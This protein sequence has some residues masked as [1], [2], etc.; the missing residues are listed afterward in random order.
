MLAQP[1]EYDQTCVD[2]IGLV[3][4]CMIVESAPATMA[5]IGAIL[6]AMALPLTLSLL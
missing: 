1:S 4:T 2:E 3:D 5:P 6:P